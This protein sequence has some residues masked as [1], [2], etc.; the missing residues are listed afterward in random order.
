MQVRWHSYDG[1]ATRQEWLLMPEE[2]RHAP[3]YRLANWIGSHLRQ[4]EGL[5]PDSGQPGERVLWF[6][7]DTL[8]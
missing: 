8:R 4:R 2:L 7:W 1:E 6:E 3:V 5:E